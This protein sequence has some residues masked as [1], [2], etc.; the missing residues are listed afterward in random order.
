[1][2]K[3]PKEKKKNWMKRWLENIQFVAAASLFMI[4]MI[5]SLVSTWNEDQN[6]LF[7]SKKT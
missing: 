1:M 7:Q 2:V 3:L 4:L 5:G 6:F